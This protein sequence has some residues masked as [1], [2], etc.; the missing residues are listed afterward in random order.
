MK[1]D[2]CGHEFKIGDFPFCPHENVHTEGMGMLGE[3]HPRFD[4]HI[5]EKGEYITSFADHKRLM[6]INHMDYR[7]KKRGMP[8]QEI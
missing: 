1:C 5:S 7:G 6:K 2:E 3:F 4:E 8:G